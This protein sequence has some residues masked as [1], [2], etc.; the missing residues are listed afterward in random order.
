M[1]YCSVDPETKAVV[2]DRGRQHMKSVR[3]RMKYGKRVMTARQAV[4]FNHAAD[5]ATKAFYDRDLKMQAFGRGTS[6]W[7]EVPGTGARLLK[8]KAGFMIQSGANSQE[9][10]LGFLSIVTGLISA[11]TTVYASR[12]ATKAAEE[13]ASAMLQ[14]AQ[15]QLEA[16]KVK[17]ASQIVVAQTGARAQAPAAQGILGGMDP[18]Q[19]LLYGGLAFLA[20]QVMRGGRRR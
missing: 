15:L 10:Q 4:T 13:Q 3:R 5:V 6:D 19:L 17:A 12:E 2:L 20:F 9:D 8:D 14:A 16:E 1:P 18:T 11:G 7:Y